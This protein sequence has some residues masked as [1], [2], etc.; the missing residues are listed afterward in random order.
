MIKEARANIEREY[1]LSLNFDDPRVSYRWKLECYAE[2][3]IKPVCC[4]LS[5]NAFL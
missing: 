4:A 2:V 1:Q 3:S 5:R